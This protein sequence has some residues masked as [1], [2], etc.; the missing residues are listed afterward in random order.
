[1]R[2]MT[3]REFLESVETLR[4]AARQT[5]VQTS[6]YVVR[7][8][9]KIPLGESKDQREYIPLKPKQHICVEWLYNDLDNPTPLSVTFE[10]HD[11]EGE[12]YD[13]FWS[14]EKLSKWLTRNAREVFD[15]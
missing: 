13:T 14:G 9:C 5:P 4:E 3:F 1:M 10:N 11:C 2:R 15:V 6:K 7:K 8:Y 12:E